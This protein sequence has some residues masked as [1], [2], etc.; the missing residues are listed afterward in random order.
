MAESIRCQGQR[1]KSR[2]SRDLSDAHSARVI[3]HGTT[4]SNAIDHPT[5]TPH[6]RPQMLIDDLPRLAGVFGLQEQRFHL[7]AALHPS[8]ER[9]QRRVVAFGGFSLKVGLPDW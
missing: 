5:V 2:T 6:G 8:A 9:S 1:Q 4:I 7:R 3:R